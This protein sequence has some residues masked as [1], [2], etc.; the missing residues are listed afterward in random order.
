MLPVGGMHRNGWFNI[1]QVIRIVSAICILVVELPFFCPR[2]YF[3]GEYS[4]YSVVLVA[5]DKFLN[6]I[7]MQDLFVFVQICVTFGIL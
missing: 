5:E 6:M 7:L 1:L 4:E 2:F 3:I